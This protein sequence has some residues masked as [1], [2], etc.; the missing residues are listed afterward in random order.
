[1]RGD[2]GCRA[3]LGGFELRD[4]DSNDHRQL[5]RHLQPAALLTKHCLRG[6]QGSATVWRLRAPHEGLVQQHLRLPANLGEFVA[7]VR[8]IGECHD[9]PLRSQTNCSL[10]IWQHPGR[11]WRHAWW[12]ASRAWCCRYAAK[13]N[14]WSPRPVRICGAWPPASERSRTSARSLDHSI[15]PTRHPPAACPRRGLHPAIMT[16]GRTACRLFLRQSAGS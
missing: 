6:H 5:H 12:M 9:G 4:E 11:S 3:R 7:S 1:M 14:H 2:V 10:N 8:G 13:L 15:S 16:A